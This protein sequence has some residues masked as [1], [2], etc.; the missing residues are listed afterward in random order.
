MAPSRII[1][2]DVVVEDARN[3]SNVH[4]PDDP[5]PGWF[6]PGWFPPPPGGIPPPPGPA[7]NTATD[8]REAARN[9]M[10]FVVFMFGILSLLEIDA[11]EILRSAGR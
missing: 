8:M 9:E 1:R 10:T 5:P 3:V 7:A 11:V 4:V 2:P 6:P